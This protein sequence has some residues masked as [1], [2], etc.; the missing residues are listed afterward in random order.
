[1]YTYVHRL[2]DLFFLMRETRGVVDTVSML[3]SNTLL[4]LAT[5]IHLNMER[6]NRLT[7]INA[8]R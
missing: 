7:I 1:M 6:T 4:K 5:L 2:S 8:G 3:G